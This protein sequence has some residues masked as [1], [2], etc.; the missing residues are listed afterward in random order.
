MGMCSWCGRALDRLVSADERHNGCSQ[1]LHIVQGMDALCKWTCPELITWLKPGKL[2]HAFWGPCPLAELLPMY[3]IRVQIKQLESSMLVLQTPN[4]GLLNIARAD[5][6][7]TA[8]ECEGQKD[9]DSRLRSL[10][11]SCDKLGRVCVWCILVEAS[12]EVLEHAWGHFSCCLRG[13]GCNKGTWRAVG[14]QVVI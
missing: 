2:Q 7:S 10:L 4:Q 11:Y 12:A 13:L 3:V 14:L 6:N 5:Q 1:L 8:V 9:C